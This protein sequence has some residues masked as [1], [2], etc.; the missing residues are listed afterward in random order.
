MNLEENALR[1]VE[2]TKNLN[3]TI[4]KSIRLTEQV[5]MNRDMILDMAIQIKEIQEEVMNIK[6]NTGLI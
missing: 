3:D 2:V 4:Q 5:K 1:I 6:R